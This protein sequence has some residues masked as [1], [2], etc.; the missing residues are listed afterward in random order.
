MRY[1]GLHLPIKYHPM[2][3]NSPLLVFAYCLLHLLASGI[4]LLGGCAPEQTIEV[5]SVIYGKEKVTINFQVKPGEVIRV[6]D[7]TGYRYEP[8]AIIQPIGH[9]ATVSHC[10]W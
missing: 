6:S 3:R 7:G 10:T 8:D 9:I 1:R 4:F 2:K 5:E